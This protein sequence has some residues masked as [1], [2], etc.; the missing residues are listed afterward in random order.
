MP[1]ALQFYVLVFQISFVDQLLSL[2]T[3]QNKKQAELC[4]PGPGAEIQKSYSFESNK[5]KPVP[6]CFTSMK[7]IKAT[8]SKNNQKHL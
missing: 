3:K 6:L 5:F 2:K 8:T 4:C 7:L 1:F